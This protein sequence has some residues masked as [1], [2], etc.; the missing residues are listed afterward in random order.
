MFSVVSAIANF[1]PSDTTC[2]NENFATG[3]TRAQLE[4]AELSF[5]DHQ[6]LFSML[7]Y[8]HF[9]GYLSAKDPSI[10]SPVEAF[11]RQ[12]NADADWSWIPLGTCFSL[13]T[14]LVEQPIVR[15]RKMLYD[16]NG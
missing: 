7:N 15:V 16:C 14:R 3:L 6:S 12:K 10:D 11:V 9:V 13:E 5:A 8:V 4:A 1:S 2:A